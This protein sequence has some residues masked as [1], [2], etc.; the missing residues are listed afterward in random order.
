VRQGR[1]SGAV[2]AAETFPL[3]DLASVINLV[4]TVLTIA[5][6]GRAV[7]SW[8]DPGM[9]SIV[10]RILFDVTEPIVRPIRRVVPP[11]GMIDLSLFIAILVVQLI[12]RLLVAAVN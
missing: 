1:G 8:F 10:G 12:A 6:L 3:S 5:L 11:I 7:L 2:R 4:F 9:R